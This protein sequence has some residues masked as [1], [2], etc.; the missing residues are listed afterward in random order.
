MTLELGD[1]KKLGFEAEFRKTLPTLL[2]GKLQPFVYTDIGTSGLGAGVGVSVDPINDMS[3]FLAGKVG[4]RTDWFK[5]IDAGGGLEAGW[6]FGKSRF[7]RVGMGW[8]MWQQ[9]DDE[10]KR[11]HLLSLFGAYR[12]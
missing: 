1:E 3:L 11:T 9:L 2:A 8:E 12:F 6:A 4:I 10:K 7:L 5:S